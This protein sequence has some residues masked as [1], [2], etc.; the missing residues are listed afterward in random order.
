MFFSIKLLAVRCRGPRL[1]LTVYNLQSLC[2]YVKRML[3]QQPAM[4]GA[5]VHPGFATAAPIGVSVSRLDK[6]YFGFVAIT[7]FAHY[8]TGNRRLNTCSKVERRE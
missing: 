4:L 8:F 1:V 3:H 6:K 2:K 7:S 5:Q